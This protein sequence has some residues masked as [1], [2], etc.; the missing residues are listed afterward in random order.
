MTECNLLL[1]EES[2]KISLFFM[3]LYVYLE[4]NCDYSMPYLPFNCDPLEQ[5]KNSSRKRCY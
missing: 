5:N 1:Y 4:E 3:F 2:S